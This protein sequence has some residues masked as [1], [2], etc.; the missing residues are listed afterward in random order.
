MSKS[1]SAALLLKQYKDLTDPK[2][3]MPSFQIE[4][5]DGNIYLWNVAV[6]VLNRESIY[7]GGYFKAEMRFP[8]DYP[9]SPPSF[10]F[11]RP[12][13]H[14][15]VYPKDGGLCIS[16]LH[17]GEDATS[18]EAPSERWSPA[19]SVESVLVSI[20]SL[21]EDPNPDSPA[22]VDA[23]VAW[24]C[25]RE[26]YNNIVRRQVE[27]S[28]EDIPAG[29]KFPESDVYYAP[30]TDDVVDE[31]FWYEDADVDEDDDDDEDDEGDDDEGDND[32]VADED[33]AHDMDIESDENVH[34]DD[35]QDV[36]PDK[37]DSVS[38]SGEDAID[39]DTETTPLK[40]GFDPSTGDAGCEPLTPAPENEK[41]D[42]H[43][44]KL[45]AACNRYESEL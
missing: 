14:P 12:F 9:F 3:T 30:P 26:K 37:D 43:G 6:M 38:E 4:L 25:D 18:G 31:S 15:N 11:L 20:L 23:S 22:N 2:C 33:D 16:I 29:F 28:K 1:G 24:R 36:C 7:Y 8:L 41:I 19:Q 21:L 42:L 10:R 17:P 32:E 27:K 44:E 5:K 45:H 40:S 35:R 13:F 39:S 34:I